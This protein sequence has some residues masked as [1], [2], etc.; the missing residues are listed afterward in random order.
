MKKEKWAFNG[1]E[2]EY[3]TGL[4]RSDK[5]F[6]KKDYVKH[7][8][9]NGEKIFPNEEM[10]C[11]KNGAFYPVFYEPTPDWIKK[12][13]PNYANAPDFWSVKIQDSFGNTLGFPIDTEHFDIV[14]F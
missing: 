6:C 3:Y 2:Q 8:I 14:T 5:A 7:K 9:V 4:N 12:I 10:V 11:F 13:D 1:L